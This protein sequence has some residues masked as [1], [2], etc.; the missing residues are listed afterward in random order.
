MRNEDPGWL[1]CSPAS[2]SVPGDLSLIGDRPVR[3]FR[4]L[5]RQI[6]GFNMDSSLSFNP[7]RKSA[8]FDGQSCAK[9]LVFTGKQTLDREWSGSRRPRAGWHSFCFL[10]F[11][12]QFM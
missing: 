12:S 2:V 4:P 9:I 1:Q 11:K 7:D 5:L 6:P 3:F 10:V 8:I